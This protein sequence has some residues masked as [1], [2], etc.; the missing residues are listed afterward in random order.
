MI[1][2][3][4]KFRRQPALLSQANTSLSLQMHWVLLSLSCPPILILILIL[5]CPFIHPIQHL[6]V[7]TNASGFSHHTAPCF[8]TNHLSAG[9]GSPNVIAATVTR[10]VGL[11]QRIPRQLLQPAPFSAITLARYSATHGPICPSS[12]WFNSSYHCT[13]YHIPGYS[14]QL[15]CYKFR[16]LKTASTHFTR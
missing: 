16:S 11:F 8:R 15:P 2:S 3:L 12:A 6:P 5:S 7:S 4:G 1:H 9:D 14:H 13:D 10:L